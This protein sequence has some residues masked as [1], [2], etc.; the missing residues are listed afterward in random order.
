MVPMGGIIMK[1]TFATLALGA[2]LLSGCVGHAALDGLSWEEEAAYAGSDS[3]CD[4]GARS[5]QPGPC[6]VPNR[7]DDR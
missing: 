3:S 1:C 5:R 4:S 2:A 7:R 6:Y